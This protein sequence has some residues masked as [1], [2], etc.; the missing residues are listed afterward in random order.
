[1]LFYAV[2]QKQNIDG[3]EPTVTVTTSKVDDRVLISVGDN[4]NGIPQNLVD[5]IFQPFFTTKPTGPGNRDW[6]YHWLM[7]S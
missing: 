4:G 2:S 1:M 5:K 6:V 3:Y 7:I